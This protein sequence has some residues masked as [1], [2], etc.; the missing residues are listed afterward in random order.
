MDLV[1]KKKLDDFLHYD[2]V[3]P[4]STNIN[5]A[6]TN[7]F[8]MAIPKHPFIRFCI[9]E[10]PNY[11]N[12]SFSYF[13][14]SSHVLQSTGPLFLTEMVKKYGN[15]PKLHIMN[16]AEY[17]GDCRV[18]NLDECEGGEYFKPIIGR[19]WFQWDYHLYVF[20]VCHYTKII[21]SVLL[22]ALVGSE[23]YYFSS[24]NKVIEEEAP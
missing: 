24:K 14:N 21:G 7:A 6:Y 19:T 15:I 4:K 5:N 2:L 1:C 16:R 23:Y 3:L 12:H 13:G 10:L 20:G 9:D 17:S 18:C 22:A 8:F 11:K